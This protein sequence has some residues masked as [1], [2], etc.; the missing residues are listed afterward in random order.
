MYHRA[1]PESPLELGVRMKKL[2][3]LLVAG[4]GAAFAIVNRK[5]RAEDVKVWR[6]ATSDSAR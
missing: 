1:K 4:V 6:D 5:Q 3:V 2:I